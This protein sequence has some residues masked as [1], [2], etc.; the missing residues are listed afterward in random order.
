MTVI[1]YRRIFNLERVGKIGG[2]SEEER[3]SLIFIFTDVLNVIFHRVC[4]LIYTIPIRICCVFLS[5]RT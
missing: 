4:L 1:Y 3:L 2:G 5:G